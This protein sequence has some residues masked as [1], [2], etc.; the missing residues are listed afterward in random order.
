[1][2]NI[3][4]TA[5]SATSSF[6]DPLASLL[7][8]PQ[9]ADGH[10]GD[11]EDPGVIGDGSNTDNSLVSIPWL[12]HVANKT[13]NGERGPVDL[14]HEKPP[15]DNP[16]ELGI[17]SPGEEPVQFDKQP[18]VDVLALGLSAANLTVLVVA[19]INTHGF[20]CR[21]ESSNISLVVLDLISF[22]FS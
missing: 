19:N 20:S 22:S 6:Q 15:Q 21:S 2:W 11:F 8:D 5:K 14:A 4:M 12:L 7:S 17:S 1:M 16:V 13:G 10:L 3:S 18:Q 9:G